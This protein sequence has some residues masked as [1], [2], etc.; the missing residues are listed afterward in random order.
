MELLEKE[1]LRCLFMEYLRYEYKEIYSH[2]HTKKAFP[3]VITSR[4]AFFNKTSTIIY[5]KIVQSFHG[6]FVY[7]IRGYYPHNHFD[8]SSKYYQL[9]RLNGRFRQHHVR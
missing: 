1:T 7:L 2:I 4:K 3:E 6:S 9:G 5:S 8:H